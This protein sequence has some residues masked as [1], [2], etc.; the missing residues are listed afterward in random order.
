[1]NAVLQNIRATEGARK[2]APEEGERLEI[3]GA[4]L[5]WKVQGKDSDVVASFDQKRA[6]FGS[7]AL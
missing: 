3:A 4:H 2:V 5:T 1:M 7:F 6:L